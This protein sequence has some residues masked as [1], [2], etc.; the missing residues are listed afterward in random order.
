MWQT[1][2]VLLI[3]GVVVVYVARQVVRMVRSKTPV[4][5]G[6]IGCSGWEGKPPSPEGCDKR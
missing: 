5:C 2:V 6:C 4:G 1:V 3:L